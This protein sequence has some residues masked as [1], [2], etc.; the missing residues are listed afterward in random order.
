V[1]GD[2]QIGIHYANCQFNLG[3]NR[4]AKSGRDIDVLPLAARASTRARK[5]KERRE[6]SWYMPKR[7]RRAK[8]EAHQGAPLFI[9][10][11]S[12]RRL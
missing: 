11:E 2:R 10:S 1:F 6:S 7:S 12:V 8:K 5:L 9:E 3:G 4:I